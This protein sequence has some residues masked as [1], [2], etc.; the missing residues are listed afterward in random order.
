MGKANRIFLLALLLV[1]L[2]AANTSAKAQTGIL[3]DPGQDGTSLRVV[4]LEKGS[5]FFRAGIRRGD[6]ILEVDFEP[7]SGTSLTRALMAVEAASIPGNSVILTLEGAE[8]VSVVRIC[9]PL[10]DSRTAPFFTAEKEILDAWTVSAG[11]WDRFIAAACRFALGH[12]SRQDFFRE[13]RSSRKSLT[14]SR[15]ML[16]AIEIPAQLPPAVKEEL[17]QSK[18]RLADANTLRYLATRVLYRSMVSGETISTEGETQP[19]EYLAAWLVQNIKSRLVSETGVPGLERG[20]G[21]LRTL[22]L[23]A[24]TPSENSEPLPKKLVNEADMA[25]TEAKDRIERISDL[26]VLAE[27]ILSYTAAAEHGSVLLL[28]RMLLRYS[29]IE[30]KANVAS[31]RGFGHLLRARTMVLSR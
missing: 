28:G 10:P 30:K 8:G 4:S 2:S 20:W 17:F 9:A 19:K 3:L 26:G 11:G 27:E 16:L 5:L 21:Y 24:R 29:E 14:R 7:L 13:L 31:G 6:I 18:S 25:L 1:G 22:Y 12:I 23:Q 15:N